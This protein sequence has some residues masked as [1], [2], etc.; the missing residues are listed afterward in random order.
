MKWLKPENHCELWL[1]HNEV[2]RRKYLES[3]WKTYEP[4]FLLKLNPWDSKDTANLWMLIPNRVKIDLQ[5][6]CNSVRISAGGVDTFVHMCT[7]CVCV[8]V[9]CVWVFVGVHE[10]DFKCLNVYENEKG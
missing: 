2:G 4:G 9:L 1:T 5:V 10:V 7:L 3:F 6:K 8:Y